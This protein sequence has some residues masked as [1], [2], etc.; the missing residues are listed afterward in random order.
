MERTMQVPDC[1][2]QWAK[3]SVP[4]TGEGKLPLRQ[5]GLRE[6]APCLRARPQAPGD[7]PGGVERD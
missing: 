4:G 5:A 3:G 2:N 6:T 7:D 1:G